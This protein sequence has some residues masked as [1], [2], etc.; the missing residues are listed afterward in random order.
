MKYNVNS[1]LQSNKAYSRDDFVFFWGHDDRG[2]NVGKSCLSQWYLCLFNVDNIYYNCAEQFMMAEKARIFGDEE[3]WQQIMA[4][5]DPMTIKKLG[6]KVRNF[7]A[8][9]WKKNCQKIVMRGNLAKFSQIPGLKEYLLGTGDKIL[10][11][12]SPKDTIW[13]IG[14]AEDAPEASNPRLWQGE[15]LLGFTLMEVRDMLREKE[16]DSAENVSEEDMKKA[17]LMWT[18]GAGNSARRFNNEDPMPEKTK[19]AKPMG[20]PL[21]M[22]VS[23]PQNHFLTAKQMDVIK[24]GHIP[25]AMED[26]WYM[27]CDDTT[28]NYLRSW[29]GFHIFEAHYEKCGDEYRITELRINNNPDE[30]RLVNADAAVAWFYALL[31]SEYGGDASAYWNA[32]F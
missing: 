23:V 18:M 6:R 20:D 19:V 26:H 4:S 8:H 3:A 16:E 14:L 27:F 21:T 1:L 13:G 10:V 2:F 5:Y 11:E 29:T 12:A 9:V 32:A 7:N 31:V 30:L 25:D 22:F 24:W 17:L 15:N 28:I